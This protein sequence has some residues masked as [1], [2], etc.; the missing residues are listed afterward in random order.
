MTIGFRLANPILSRRPHWR[1]EI[2]HMAALG[3][4]VRNAGL[5]QSRTKERFSLTP[6]KS[7]FVPIFVKHPT[8]L[9]R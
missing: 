3:T 8:S 4:L 1:G 7:T 9:R 6:A 2:M 5:A